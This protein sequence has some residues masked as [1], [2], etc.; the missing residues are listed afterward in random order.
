[1]TG[2]R[3]GTLVAHPSIAKAV[4]HPKSKAPMPPLCL[5]G[6]LAALEPD[7]SR[8]A[9]DGMLEFLIA[10]VSL[11]SMVS[12]PLGQTCER[13]RRFH[14]FQVLIPTVSQLTISSTYTGRAEGC[15]CVR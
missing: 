15:R 10:V 6:A 1:M 4:E 5:R 13:K 2:W 9:I 3:L 8:A 11:S 14:L 12:T 7:Q